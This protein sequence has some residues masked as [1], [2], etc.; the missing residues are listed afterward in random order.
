[1]T[2]QV[3]MYTIGQKG[4]HPMQ[5]DSQATPEKAKLKRKEYEEKLR[6]LQI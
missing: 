3:V 4:H 2:A 6:H 1:M 5:N